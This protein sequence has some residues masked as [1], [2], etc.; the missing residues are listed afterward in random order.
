MWAS[1]P[2]YAGE[3]HELDPEDIRGIVEINGVKYT[4][5]AY[6]DN[7]GELM[8]HGRPI[9]E[10]TDFQILKSVKTMEKERAT[11]DRLAREAFT[12]GLLTKVL[13]SLD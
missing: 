1:D 10:A 13:A 2:L 8:I 3:V 9:E 5:I 6:L 4:G 12:A 11:R 7:N